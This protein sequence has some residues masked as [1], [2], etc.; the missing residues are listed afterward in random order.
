MFRLLKGT[1]HLDEINLKL[2]EDE[3]IQLPSKNDVTELLVTLDAK[4]VSHGFV[5]LS[6]NRDAMFVWTLDINKR[7]AKITPSTYD[8]FSLMVQN[9]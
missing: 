1:F 8:Y 3:S 4:G 2:D 7:E 5:L 6:Y 9:V